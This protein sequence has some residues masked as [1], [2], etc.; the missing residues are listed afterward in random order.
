[1]IRSL[2]RRRIPTAVSAAVVLPAAVAGLYFVVFPPAPQRGP[3]G[4]MPG[5][6]ILPPGSYPPGPLGPGSAVPDLDADGWLNGSPPKKSDPAVR[7]ILLDI[8]SGW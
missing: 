3:Y 4:P 1:M 6:P 5:R 2:F 8:W 7:L